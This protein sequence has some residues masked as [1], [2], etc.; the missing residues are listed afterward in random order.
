VA[1]SLERGRLEETLRQVTDLKEQL[2]HQA[3]HDPLTGLPNRTL[4]LDRTRQAVEAA[5]RSHVWPAVLYV[6]LDGFKPVNDSHGHD[7]GDLLLR[8]VATRIRGCL[9]P[10]DTAAR[11]GGDEFAVLLNGPIDEAGIDRVLARLRAQ[12]D[13]PVDLGEGRIATIG[14][15]IGVARGEGGIADADA[16]I[17]R[18]DV[19]MY[20]AKRSGGS[21]FLVYE[22]GMGDSGGCR[23]DAETELAA[24][25]RG[26]ELSVAYQPLVD[27]RTGRPI[28]AEA[29]VRWEHPDGLRRPEEFIGL[30]E[31]TGLI[32][33]LGVVVLR[34]ACAQAARWAAEVTPET[35]LLVTVNLSA[36]QL[37]DPGIVRSVAD[38]LADS[39]LEPRRL[40]L[41][42]T[43]TV[44]M[45]DRDAAAA[46]LW[47]L[48]GLGVR[49]AIDDFGTGYSSLAYLRRFPIDMLKVAREFV[50]GLGRDA[51]DDAI[52]RAI[53][54][55][56]TTLGMLTIAEGIETTQQQEHVAALGCDLAQGYLFSHP[57]D[58]DVVL[59]L[60]AA[61]RVPDLPL[62]VA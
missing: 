57:V 10:A 42:I 13:V 33:E 7:A 26:G 56:A 25:I 50:D 44:L 47:R 32:T 61:R 37:A 58:A 3:L 31:D 53:V 60:V 41:E 8:T 52:T 6:D 18:A 21:A 39:G 59:A 20:A 15:S 49:I 12:L 19:A 9:R 2:R 36:R 55:L 62:P 29:L 14:M 51:N 17:R 38:A 48:K 1:T 28:G 16:L 40:V 24:A 5:A 35:E 11:L 46:T 22:P 4:F 43:E 54:D 27:M 30:A 23:R 45:Q 34:D